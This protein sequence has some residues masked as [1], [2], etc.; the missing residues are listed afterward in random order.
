MHERGVAVVGGGP[1]G[2]AAA[3]RLHRAGVPV[4]VFEAEEWLG[5]R[6]RTDR[7]EGFTIDAGAQLFGSMFTRFRELARQL[8]LEGELIRASGRDALWRE[9]RAHEVVYGSV[10]SML[11]SGGLSWRTKMRLGTTY[12]PFLQRH[13]D[14]LDLHAPE[15]AAEAGLDQESIAEWGQ[16]ALDRDF[17]EH[18]VYPQLSAYYGAL[19][20]ETA[21]G[22]YHTLARYGIDVSVY[23]L[24]SGAAS[25]YEAIA[26]RLEAAGREVKRGTRVEALEV[27]RQAVRVA[28]G[29]EVR[30]FAGAVVATPAPVACELLRG[31]PAGL[32]Q[33]LQG[34]RYRPALTVALLLDQSFPVRYFGI[35]F[36]RSSARTV[37]AA[38]VEENKH[39]A[40][41]P[42]GKGLVVAF[43]RPDV[44]PD[45]V[46]AEPRRILDA[47]L[48][49]LEGPFPGI[50]AR[51]TRAKVYRWPVGNPVFYP[52]YLSRLA[53]F[54]RQG[55]EEDA[56]VAVA[57]DYQY[58]SSVEGAVTA[59]LQAAE[60][61]LA[62]LGGATA[63]QRV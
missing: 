47:V 16:R 54:R 44:A 41:V 38:C 11:A 40:L 36:A 49:D 22:L 56:P 51:I 34:V 59:G 55:V 60:R 33:W 31:A 17:V 12:V 48:P 8:G 18:L 24:R 45:L 25:L 42:E 14:V 1:A 6:T 43:A 26:D 7:L 32:Q 52:G 63:D 13:S 3:W 46:Q 4:T 57:G 29:G 28:L 61:L 15:L 30:D 39:P 62:R 20:E 10:T 53:V 2:M 5:G 19:P 27:A 21:A 35:S 23:A 50:E 37:V 9:G 58:A